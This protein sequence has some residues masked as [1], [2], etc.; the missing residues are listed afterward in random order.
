M[1]S[2]ITFTSPLYAMLPRKPGNKED[3]LGK[4]MKRIA[5]GSDDHHSHGGKLLDNLY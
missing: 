1:A 3:L 2:I 4:Y 5:E